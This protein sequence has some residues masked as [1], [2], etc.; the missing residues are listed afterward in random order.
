MLVGATCASREF[1]PAYLTLFESGELKSRVDRAVKSLRCCTGCPRDC[2]VDRL[3]NKFAVCRNGRYAVVSSHFPHHGEEDCLR[4]WRGSGTI[5]FS[6]FSYPM[7]DGD[8]VGVYPVFESLDI[9][10][11]T[12]IRPVPLRALRFLLDVHVGRLAAYLRMAGFDALYDDQASDAELASIV[13]RQGR[14]LLTRDRYLLMRTAVDRGYWVRS[15]DRNSSC[16]RWSS[17]LTSPVP[18][19]RSRAA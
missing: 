11:V 6:G 15:T 5:F 14:V 18:C 2:W 12:R 7:R 4:G 3:Q 16:S 17:G 10:S 1:R 9:S 19:D 8:R 13:V